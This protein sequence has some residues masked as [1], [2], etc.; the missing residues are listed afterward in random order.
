MTYL[1]KKVLGRVK[2]E[3]NGKIIREFIGLKPK[4]YALSAKDDKEQ[5]KAK[6]I[7]KQLVKRELNFNLYKKTLGENY[8]SKVNFNSIR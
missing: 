5:K 3:V 4:M 6:G 7:P 2:D 8:L 1:I